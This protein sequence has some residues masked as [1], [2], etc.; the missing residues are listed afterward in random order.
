MAKARCAEGPRHPSWLQHPKRMDA[1]AG[2][3]VGGELQ[4]SCS[5]PE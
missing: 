5:S 2:L 1:T 3:R 4:A